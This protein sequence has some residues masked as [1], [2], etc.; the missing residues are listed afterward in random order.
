MLCML[1]VPTYVP[2]HDLLQFMSPFSPQMEHI[3]VIRD[4]KPSVYMVLLKFRSQKATDEFFESFNGKPFNSIEGDICHLVY[5]AKVSI[6]FRCTR[7]LYFAFF[8]I[9]RSGG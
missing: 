4:S 9:M 3:R 1:A 8:G 2:L 6:H 5:V 7:V